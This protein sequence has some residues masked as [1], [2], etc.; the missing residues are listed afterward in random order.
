VRP[1]KTLVS[2]FN[3]TMSNYIRIRG[4]RE[5]N[6]KAINVDLPKNRLVVFTGVSGSGK[7]SLA[8]DTIYAEGQRRYVESLSSYARQFLGISAKPDVELIEGLSPAIAISQKKP[9]HNPRSTVGTITEIY[10]YLRL[11]FSKVGHPHCPNCG[12][13]VKKQSVD[14][15]V[16]AVLEMFKKRHRLI[17]DARLL[18]LAPVV[19]DKKGEYST[20]FENLRKQGFSR[21]RIDGELRDLDEDFVLIKTNRHSVE[22]VIDRIILSA[23]VNRDRLRARLSDAIS[24][25]L[26]LSGGEVIVSEVQ[27]ASFTF[28]EKPK[29]M[30]DHLF[31]ELFACPE[32]NI[33]LSE[34]EP[35]NFS[36]N[37]PHGACPECEGLG[38][39]L[40][41]DPERIYNSRLSISEG[42][43][44]PLS[45]LTTNDTWYR[46]LLT[47]VAA[48]FNFS[49][50]DPISNLSPKQLEILTYGVAG[51]RFTVK[52]RNRHGK[53]T[54]FRES[55]PGVIAEIEKRYSTTESERVRS[56]LEGYMIQEI[57]P[58]CGGTRLKPEALA[59]TVLG[60]NISEVTAMSINN[61]LSWID[62]LADG[63]VIEE[64]ERAIAEPIIREIHNR[65][66]FL[67]SVGLSYLTLNRAAATLSGG[68]AQRIR[69]ASQIGSGLSGVIYVLDEPSVG[70]HHRDMGR[71]I[72]TL[73]GLRDL[74]NTVIVVEHDPLT[75]READWV[76]DF[77]PGGGKWGG[78]VVA[79]GTP[80]EIMENKRSLTGDYLAGRKS[81][82]ITRFADR[83]KTP[84]TSK[85]AKNK[86]GYL[87]VI[88][89]REHNLKNID[90]EFPLGKLICITGVSGSGKSTLVMETLLRSLRRELGYRIDQPPGEH[91]G[92]LGVE[93][94]D[95]VYEIDQSPIGQTP[96]SNPATY[97]KAFDYIRE[98]FAR[99]KEARLRGFDKGHFSFN[100]KGGRCEACQ[101]QGLE[102]IEMQFLPDVYVTCEVC[103]GAR[104]NR[105]ALEVTYK[106][107]NIKEVLDMTVGE[108][109]KF[110]EHIPPL[111][112]RLMTL[113]D[114]GLDYIELGQ[115]APTL[116]GGEAQR[117]RLARELSKSPKGHTFYILDE[118]TI[119]L[120]PDD[121]AKLLNVLHRLVSL[122]NTVLLI[123]HNLDVI[124][125]ADWIID[126]G[127]EG[128]ESG[129]EVVFVGPPEKIVNCERSYTGQALKDYLQC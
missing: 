97:T 7:S 98:A 43:I 24:Q 111:T 100:T 57:C 70:L 68:E 104:Y 93:N 108:A 115:P 91:D 102:K 39:K 29:R 30:Q 59:V 62:H 84:R 34:L 45:N 21:A 75:I 125:N 83:E 42:G 86:L 58:S 61:C 74:D 33:S 32:C 119:G 54:T 5:H 56:G 48:K 73:K 28:P 4:A 18:I 105:E 26:N 27:D 106:G 71:L 81:V 9:F 90:V 44:L 109:L 16:S 82:E 19:R 55:F 122:D 14:E 72:S 1:G 11:L 23:K 51:K 107:K 118:P 128:G 17:K 22:V 37:T 10:D 65:L 95:K 94:I 3:Y 2:N 99:T 120:H 103:N 110:F 8:L 124:K 113:S 35:R 123:E 121:L 38:T 60:K 49:L 31:S 126:L 80:R 36:F 96:R 47:A 88:G 92:L 101:G 46:R 79:A 69:L 50:D 89:A 64:R 87:T 13:E 63:T 15:I 76:L 117:V 127:P 25:A 116:S 20:L 12:R 52:G 77:G 6:L 66:R 85:R 78:E 67:N 53:L 114:V 41:V 40:K 129:G 112:R